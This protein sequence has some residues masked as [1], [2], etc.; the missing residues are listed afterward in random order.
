M[1]VPASETDSTRS[2][3]VPVAEAVTDPAQVSRPATVTEP[4][5]EIVKVESALSRSRVRWP[6]TSRPGTPARATSPTTSLAVT[7]VPVTVTVPAPWDRLRAAAPWARVTA[8]SVAVTVRPLVPP[9][10]LMVPRST[11]SVPTVTATVP[12]RAVS[13]VVLPVVPIVPS[14]SVRSRVAGPSSRLPLTSVAVTVRVPGALVIAK[15]PARLPRPATAT[16]AEPESCRAPSARSSR[17]VVPGPVVTV[18]G[19]AARPVISL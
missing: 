3:P 4:L 13:V 10:T 9:L 7:E 1:S 2:A 6:A 5:P 8:T 14:T 16:V 12:C 15:V 17:T 19:A 11:A 18:T